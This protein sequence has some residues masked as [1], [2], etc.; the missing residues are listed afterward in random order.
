MPL[1]EWMRKGGPLSA[2][3]HSLVSSDSFASEIADPR[4]LRSFIQQ[5]DNRQADHCNVLWSLIALETWASIFLRSRVQDLRL[6]GAETGKDY[7]KVR[8]ALCAV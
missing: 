4:R 6:P 1:G 8:R 3:V 2:R 5:H 7:S